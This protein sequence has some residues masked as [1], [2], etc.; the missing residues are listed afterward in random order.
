MEN[1]YHKEDIVNIL[2]INKKVSELTLED[3]DRI[4]KN[5]IIILFKFITDDNYFIKLEKETESS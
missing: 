5:R 4:Y 2:N 3:L 1:I